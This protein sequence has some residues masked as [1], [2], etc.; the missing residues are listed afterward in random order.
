MKKK[1]IVK[2]TAEMKCSN[3]IKRCKNCKSVVKE[4]IREHNQNWSQTRDHPYRMLATG[5]SGSVKTN[6]SFDLINQ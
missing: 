6:S 1:I 2:N 3:V 4:N 5:S